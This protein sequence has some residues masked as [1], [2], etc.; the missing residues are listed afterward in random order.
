MERFQFELNK[1]CFFAK[2]LE[3]IISAYCFNSEYE[4]H[5]RKCLQKNIHILLGEEHYA[6]KTVFMHFICS[7]TNVDI[8]YNYDS[9]ITRTI[10][11]SYTFNMSY[12]D[13]WN[14]ICDPC[15]SHLKF[16]SRWK[17]LF[18]KKLREDLSEIKC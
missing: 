12:I 9:N 11:N 10:H 17:Y 2:S 16:S 5:L 8:L 18:L 6:P 3:S 4:L 1:C 13:L 15:S 14:A 7:D